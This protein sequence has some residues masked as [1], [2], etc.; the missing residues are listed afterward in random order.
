MTVLAAFLTWYLTIQLTS[1]AALPLVLRFFAGLPDRGYVFAKILGPFLVGVTLWLGTSYGLLRNEAGGAW[2]ALGVV[3]GLTYGFGGFRLLV[4]WTAQPGGLPMR[5]RWRYV[6]GVEV[7]FLV[8]FAIWTWV[9]INDPAANHTE[10]PMDLMFMNSIWNS[11]TFPPRDAWLAGYPI[12]Y[13]YLG[14]WLLTTLGHLSS[15]PPAV[16]YNLGQASWY[17]LLLTGSFGVVY[18]LAALHGA[19]CTGDGSDE[20]GEDTWQPRWAYGMAGLLAAALAG[21]IGNLQVILEWLYAQGVN[22]RSMAAWFGVNGFPENAQTSGIWYIGYDWWWWRSSRVISDRDLL[23]GHLEVIDEFPMFSYVLGDNHPHV[24]AMPVVLVVIAMALAVYLAAR[25]SGPTALPDARL[26]NAARQEGA[27]RVWDAWLRLPAVLPMGWAGLALIVAVSGGLV[28]MN[29]WDYPPYLFLL[30][31]ALFAGLVTSESYRPSVGSLGA[32]IARSAVV[33]A[34]FGAALAAGTLAVYLPYFLTA[35]SQAG[36]FVPNLF[37]PT[38]L[39]Q[40]LLMFGVFVPAIIGWMAW[41]WRIHRPSSRQ[42][43]GSAAVVFGLPAAFLGVSAA[44][45]VG[46]PAG[47]ALL[48]RMA[49]PDGATSHLPFI[50]QRWTQQPF[51]LLAFGALLAV[52]AAL[53]WQMMTVAATQARCAPRAPARTDLFVMLLAA[54]GLLL[55]YVPE[56]VFLR[57]NFGTRMNTVFKFY[58]QAWLLLALAASYAVGVGLFMK[59]QG[60]RVKGQGN[61]RAISYFLFPIPYLLTLGLAA[62]ALIYPGAATY[63]KTLGFSAQSRSADA[64]Q[65]VANE[66]P[67]EKAAVEWVMYNTSPDALVLEGRGA[68][69]RSTHNRIS[70]MTGRP[71]LLGWDGHES[72][73][74][75]ESYGE[76]ARGR[77]EAL[78]SVYR[79]GS[80]AEIEQVLGQWGIDYVYVGPSER[81]QYGITPRSEER[82]AAVMR[83][84]FEEGDVRI[85]QRN[86]HGN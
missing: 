86:G 12:S 14:Y 64:T 73:W 21:V 33:T 40:A 25:R 46:T 43:A 50:V 66:S 77:V 53:I 84:V 61:S 72:Q 52:A 35:Q 41:M 2:L 42:A 54:L 55:A 37:N 48:Q 18:N 60:S 19:D 68:S 82:I 23:G 36:G 4:K 62:L 6:A 45:A 44:L 8:A 10:Q 3:A 57:D 28:F 74:R 71:T 67:D 58:Y 26:G 63:S 59:A 32:H 75:G 80:P 17:G 22:I 7:L 13:Y 78:D 79:V 24:L 27:P 34:T 56:F 65:Y 69:Y 11:P 49:L 9:R 85:Y 38:R 39:R 16:A 51:T 30:T 1:V 76:M 47:K 81:E 20:S 5:N 70:T 15:M 83:L 29:T 31:G